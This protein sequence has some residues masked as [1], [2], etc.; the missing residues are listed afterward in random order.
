VVEIIS[1]KHL[2]GMAEAGNLEE[3]PP[4]C[5]LLEQCGL[6]ARR[7]SAAQSEANR[8]FWAPML[9]RCGA[10][11]LLW[12]GLPLIALHLVVPRAAF[13]PA[14]EDAPE[15]A[16]QPWLGASAFWYPLP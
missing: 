4:L 3:A 14:E 8:M 6:P 2:G 1:N 9:V 11:E 5:R 13:Q 16:P 7:L 12:A 10:L 15:P